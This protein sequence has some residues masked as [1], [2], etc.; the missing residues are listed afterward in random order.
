MIL[1]VCYSYVAI[2]ALIVFVLVE[3]LALVFVRS[4]VIS[5]CSLVLIGVF[6]FSYIFFLEE[7]GAFDK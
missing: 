2:V 6:K 1:M 4:L 3:R 7:G 5:D